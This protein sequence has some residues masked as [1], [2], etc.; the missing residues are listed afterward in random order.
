MDF[1]AKFPTTISVRSE[2]GMD[3]FKDSTYG[4][5]VTHAARVRIV[6]EVGG[7]EGGQ[8]TREKTT[9]HTQAD[10]SDSDLIWFEGESTT[11]TTTGRRF[12][13]KKRSQ[14]VDGSETVYKYEFD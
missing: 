2:S 5:A 13:K 3:M 12:R 4:S 10:L 1:A 8:E 11:D 6:E 14:S 9:V 7:T